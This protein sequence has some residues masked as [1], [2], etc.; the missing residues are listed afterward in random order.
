[1]GSHGEARE[2]VCRDLIFVHVALHEQR[3][4]CGRSHSLDGFKIGVACG[5]KRRFHAGP[6]RIGELFHANH[7]GRIHHAAGDRKIP[8]AQG[9]AS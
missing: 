8:L 4:L 1:M 3:R 2:P 7:K 9:R 5:G 6:D